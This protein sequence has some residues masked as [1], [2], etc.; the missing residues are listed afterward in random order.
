[1]LVGR[2]RT[3][4]PASWELRCAR[5]ELCRHIQQLTR[6]GGRHLSGD[7]AQCRGALSKKLRLP[8]YRTI[9]HRVTLIL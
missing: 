5:L 9:Y 4:P 6:D 8:V 7:V 1:M 2:S 3:S